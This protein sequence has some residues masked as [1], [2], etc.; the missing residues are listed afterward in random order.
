MAATRHVNKRKY[1]TRSG[2][3]PVH[4]CQMI[5][6]DADKLSSST[7]KLDKNLQTYDR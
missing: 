7:A 1:A 3:L 2:A 5:Y 6:N 4:V